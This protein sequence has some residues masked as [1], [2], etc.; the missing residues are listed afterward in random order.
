M[1]MCFINRIIVGE[2]P[3]SKLAQIRLNSSRHFSPV[4]AQVLGH[5]KDFAET[6]ANITVNFM[7]G[8]SPKLT[9]QAKSEPD[10]HELCLLSCHVASKDCAP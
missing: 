6:F 8:K 5:A 10:L 4:S 7:W 9:V 2:E 1:I 3:V